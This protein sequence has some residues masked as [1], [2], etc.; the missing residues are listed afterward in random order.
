[1]KRYP[2]AKV[3]ESIIVSAPDYFPTVTRY[4]LQAKTFSK[5]MFYTV[6]IVWLIVKVLIMN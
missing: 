2:A 6:R 5:F 1:M 3:E 4:L